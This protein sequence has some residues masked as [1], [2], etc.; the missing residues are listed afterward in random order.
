MP[1]Q[2]KFLDQ[3]GLIQ[4][5]QEIESLDETNIKDLYWSTDNADTNPT[6][7]FKV[8]DDSGSPH[9]IKK[10]TFTGETGTAPT[11]VTPRTLTIT[12]GGVNKTITYYDT[13]NSTGINYSYVSDSSDPKTAT[14]V[15][16]ALDRVITTLDN[17]DPADEK[18]NQTATSANSYLPLLLANGTTP[19]NGGAQYN[20]AISYNPAGELLILGN[21][22]SDRMVIERGTISRYSTTSNSDPAWEITAGGTFTGISAKADADSNGNNIVNT[23]ATKAA[24]EA[25]T[26][27]LTSSF[28]IVTA[29]PTADGTHGGI[30]YLIKDQEYG[31]VNNN[32]FKEYIEVN[33]GTTA[34]PSWKFELIGT[35]DAGIDVVTIPATGANSVAS[36]FAQYITNA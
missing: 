35:T 3:N 30:I 21:P 13:D 17:I 9:S 5:L 28:Q 2:K 24:L 18:V 34:S 14:K 4:L 10:L 6:V 7:V 36:M 22:T 31:D 23:Y 32:I 12:I 20:S 1:T 27:Q 25:L 33:D 26:N 29:L 15:K 19:S 16:E 8:G 11:G